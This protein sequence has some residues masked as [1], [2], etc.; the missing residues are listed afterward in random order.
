MTRPAELEPS[1]MSQDIQRLGLWNRM[2]TLGRPLSFE[3][4]VTPRCNND[5]RHCY[6]NLPANDAHARS[7]ELSVKEIARIGREAVAMGAVWC[8]ITGGE[9]LLREDFPEIY[10]ALRRRGVL[11]SVFTTAQLIG[12]E[13]VRLFRRCPPRDIEVTVYGATLATYERVT[14][15]PGAN[16]RRA[17]FN[18]HAIVVRHAHRI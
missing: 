10:L 16:D 13:H 3:L 12:S 6:I 17:L 18:G 8:L 7:T 5:C 2:K 15:R 11:V 14:R 9:P 4:E 1:V